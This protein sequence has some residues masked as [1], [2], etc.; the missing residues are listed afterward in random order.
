M[1]L[2]ISELAKKDL[3]SIEEY[4]RDNWGKL[5]ADNYLSQIEHRILSLLET[6]YLGTAR[7]D[8]SNGYRCLPEGRHIIFYRVDDEAVY[9]IGVPHASMDLD[10]HLESE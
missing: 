10:R 5:Q 6:P 1:E 8:V 2:V 4:T 3:A 7:P 9:I